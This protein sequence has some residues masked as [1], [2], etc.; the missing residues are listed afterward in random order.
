MEPSVASNQAAML[1]RVD[2]IHSYGTRGA[3]A[4]LFVSTRDYR[5]LGYRVPSE[6]AAISKELRGMES[7]AAFKR[8]SRAGFIR[9]YHLFVCGVRDC[10]VCGG[11]W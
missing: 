5:A 10:Y 2:R 1:Q 4:G 6:W 11:S 9:D 8:A 3:G 7:L